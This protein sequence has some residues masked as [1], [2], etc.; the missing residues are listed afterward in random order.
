MLLID[1]LFMLLMRLHQNF[2]EQDLAERF[3]IT[4]SSVSRK[5]L[6]WVSLLYIILGSIP[7]WI[8]K[9]EIKKNNAQMFQI[10]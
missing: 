10:P 5:L 2:P 6:T 3:R 4:E 7:I 8:S 9:E 1:E